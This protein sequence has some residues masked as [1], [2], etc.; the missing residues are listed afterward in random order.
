M[1]ALSPSGTTKRRIELRIVRPL[2]AWFARPTV[3]IDG[4]GHPAQWGVGTWAVPDDG[5][6]IVG[7]YLFNRV[8]RFGSATAVVPHDAAHDA[9]E[10]RSGWLPVGSG[11]LRPRPTAE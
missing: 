4:I 5:G 11:R 7:V 8:W 2:F 10:Y 9:F 3:T 1:D 6:T